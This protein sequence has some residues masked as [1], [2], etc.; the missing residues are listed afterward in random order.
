MC[1]SVTLPN[2]NICVLYT[3]ILKR[4][5]TSPHNPQE[6]SFSSENLYLLKEI[7]VN[8]TKSCTSSYVDFWDF[9]KCVALDLNRH[10]F[11]VRSQVTHGIQVSAMVG[12]FSSS[13]TYIFS[14]S[15]L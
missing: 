5:L 4:N 7:K 14:F 9:H 13:Y 11:S 10:K 2:T 6:T 3:Y 8:L 12:Y 1:E 15:P